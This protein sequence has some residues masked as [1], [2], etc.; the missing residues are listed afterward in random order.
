MYPLVSIIT[1]THGRAAFLRETLRWFQTQT[2]PNLEWLILD[3]SPEACAPLADH[4]DRRIRYEH[5]PD[6][7]TV[8]EKRN[9][10]AA[11]ARGEYIAHFDDD[12]YYSPNYVAT[13][14]A[15][16]AAQRADFANLCTWYVY[17]ALHDFLG[18]WQLRQTVGAHYRCGGDGV[19]IVNFAADNRPEWLSHL[20]YGFSYV[21]RRKVW[22]SAPFGAVNRVEEEAFIQAAMNK[23]KLLSLEDQS[24]MVLHV[25]HGGSS[26]ACFPQFH[27]P[28]FLLP[29]LFKAP[30]EFLLALRQSQAP[31]R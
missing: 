6:R 12:D 15:N 31:A 28:T 13:M 11:A 16:L 30:S 17:D 18:F 7:L 4:P 20:G 9:R 29:V 26:T 27:L 24:G 1:P 21:Y 14:V 25:L 5:Q 23:F 10:L 8:G 19:E 22:Q 2:Y 3:D